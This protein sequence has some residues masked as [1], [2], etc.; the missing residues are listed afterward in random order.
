MAKY[1]KTKRNI[2]INKTP[3]LYKYSVKMVAKIK[4]NEKK[5]NRRKRDKQNLCK[6]EDT[7]FPL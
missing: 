3:R 7:L 5:K 2:Q 6:K 4:E 1:K